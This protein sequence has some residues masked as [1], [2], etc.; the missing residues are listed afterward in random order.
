[1][2]DDGLARAI[3][4]A[5]AP[6]DGD[7]V[8]AVSMAQKP[9]DAARAVAIPADQRILHAIENHEGMDVLI[10]A[11]EGAFGPHCAGAIQQDQTQRRQTSQQQRDDYHYAAVE[12]WVQPA[13]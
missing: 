11:L 5:H 13:P 9:L 3:R 8:I 7:T 12:A 10:K 6:M 1:M 4:P 2:A